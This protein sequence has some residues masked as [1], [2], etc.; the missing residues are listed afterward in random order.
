MEVCTFLLES[1][2]DPSVPT[3]QGERAFNIAKTEE[4]SKLIEEWPKD[5]TAKAMEK[6]QA[7]IRLKWEE[8]IKDSANREQLAQQLIEK[9][10]VDL[11]AS[12]KDEEL[13]NKLESHFQEA[14]ITDKAPRGHAEIRDKQGATLLSIAI[15]NGHLNV[16]EA[17]IR[18][19]EHVLNSLKKE[20]DEFQTQTQYRRGRNDKTLAE[21][22]FCLNV[23]TRDARGWTPLCIAAFKRSKKILQYLLEHGGD[24]RLKNFYGKLP[25]DFVRK[26]E[27]MLGNVND[28]GDPAMYEMLMSWDARFVEIDKKEKKQDNSSNDTNI[29]EGGEKIKTVKEKV[30]EDGNNKKDALE[31]KGGSKKKKKGGGVSKDSSKKKSSTKKKRKTKISKTKVRTKTGHHVHHIVEEV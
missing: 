20:G 2:A 31:K 12:G 10:L 6:L 5:K 26:K 25:I 3:K 30:E 19:S 13:M 4:L 9:E 7:Q 21:K 22:V 17:L 14:D 27:D 29:Q 1:G 24:P 11:A 15:S 8:R 23:N 18:K 28:E 16:V